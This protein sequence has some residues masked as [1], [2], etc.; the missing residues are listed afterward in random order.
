MYKVLVV[1]DSLDSQ[2]LVILLLK[3]IAEVTCTGSVVGALDWNKKEKFDLFLIDVMLEDGD[4]FSLTAQLR[5]TTHGRNAPVIFLTSE[6]QTRDK[7]VGFQLGAED[8]IV[9]PFDPTEFFV[10]VQS[11]LQKIAH[12]KKENHLVRGNLRLE[13][14]LQKAYFIKENEV[15]PLTPIEFKILFF[16]MVHENDVISREKL[17]FAIWG[18]GVSVG[19]SIDTHVNSLRRKLNL[20]A[21]YIQSVY[22]LGYRFCLQNDLKS[23]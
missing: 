19:R 3:S 4:G 1:E 9:K 21:F 7:I 23:E 13:V 8:Y 5:Q 22:G 16:L 20:Y 6:G 12:A 18:D 15:I 14:P 10:R 17:V 2:E 11:R